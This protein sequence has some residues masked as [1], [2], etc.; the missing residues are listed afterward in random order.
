MDHGLDE[1]GGEGRI[2]F[3]V[4]RLSCTFQVGYGRDTYCCGWHWLASIA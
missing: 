3:G 1:A 2:F 4:E